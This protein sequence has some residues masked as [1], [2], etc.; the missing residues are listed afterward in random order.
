[1]KLTILSGLMGA[2]KTTLARELGLS[3]NTEIVCRDDLRNLFPSGSE[4]ELT[5][6]LVKV[7]H[8]FL[9]HG[10]SV[11]V[12][13]CNLHPDD[14]K[15]WINLANEFGAVFKWV[16]LSTPIELCIERDARRQ[17]PNGSTAITATAAL[18][19]SRLRA[20]ERGAIL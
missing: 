17:S 9:R 12:D 4:A 1:M 16:H 20:F 6:R 18:Y 5:A 8:T 15:R 3:P 7:A 13:S 2:G 10:K 11:V 14:E 19:A